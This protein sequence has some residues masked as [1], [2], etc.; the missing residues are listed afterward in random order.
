MD[1][2]GLPI[3]TTVSG[4]ASLPLAVGT[5][6]VQAGSSG[7][8]INPGGPELPLGFDQRLALLQELYQRKHAELLAQTQQAIVSSPNISVASGLT[9][10]LINSD[11]IQSLIQL[12]L[13]QQAQQYANLQ[14]TTPIQGSNQEDVEMQASS[15][16]NP[17]SVVNG[18][19]TAPSTPAAVRSR[20][21]L[22][23]SGQTI[24]QHT[25]DRLKNMIATKKQKQQRLGSSGSSS[26][27]ATNLAVGPQ[28]TNGTGSLT[29]VPPN[30]AA[31]S[32]TNLMQ[33]LAAAAQQ[34]NSRIPAH[35]VASSS[36]FEPYPLPSSANANAAGQMSD[37]QLRKVNSEPNLKMK[38]RARL[39]NKGSSPVAH[40]PPQVPSGLQFLA[41]QSGH[42]QLQRCD[43]DSVQM[44]TLMRS[45]IETPLT[46]TNSTSTLPFPANLMIP[47]PSLPN[48]C[49]GLD[50]LR[51]DYTNLMIQSAFTSF[52]SMPS[53]LK[54]QLNPNSI[55]DPLSADS[56]SSAGEGPSTRPTVK[57]DTRTLS[58]PLPIGGY[59][60]LL[61]QQLRDLVL[62]RKSLVRE[63]PEDEQLMENISQR[64]Q[65][66]SE[67][68]HL[69]QLKTGLAYDAAMSKHQCLCADNSNHV[70]HGGR[71]HS[72]WAR[73][74]E[75]GL[76]DMCERVQMRKATLD[77][78]KL[79]H[80]STYVTFF[81][82]SP[83]ACLKLDPSE[84]PLKSFVPLPCGGIGV[85]SDTYFN[86]ANTQLASRVAVGTLVELSTQ[87]VEGKLKNGFA[88]I[89]PPGHHAEKEQ[90]MGF[91]YF[92][93]VSIATKNLQQKYSEKCKKIA[94]VDWDVHHG[95]GTQLCFDS[96]PNVL[97]ISLHRHDN[98][99][100]FPG[101]GAV[102]DTG[103]EEG[104]GFSVNIPF[105]GDIMGDTEYLAAWRIVVLPLLDAFKPEFIFV[106]AGFDAAK[107]HS[108]AL[109]GYELSPQIF[110][111]FTKTLLNFAN[112]RI[113]LALEGGY[114]L[115][116]ICD[117]AEECVK[118]LCAEGG[119]L[120]RLSPEVLEGIPNQAAQDT[121]Q[122]VI[123][124]HK[125][126]WPCLTGL[127]GLNT[128]ELHWQTIS[129]RFSSL[130][131]HS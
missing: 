113:V 67:T 114:D 96:D 6:D 69:N 85:D 75:R 90:A 71:L 1:A 76:V 126:S 88:C 51:L 14:Q 46:Q 89:R 74:Q 117:S 129:Q 128:S 23:G 44:E 29:W 78:L 130:T 122:K 60:S 53:L 2:N 58:S 103:K 91:C 123:A 30:M 39:L 49:N 82:V 125:K 26:G 97:Y 48:L 127:Q 124:I 40:P 22:S 31:V 119:E 57:F 52:L 106:S 4:T 70:E 112:G 95:N 109:G 5:E 18:E 104:K 66:L 101:T 77:L 102:T 110:G 100:F 80:S 87:V 116:S 11:Y 13:S 65:A 33:Q 8:G 16:S 120:T 19:K 115:P 35:S 43:S 99:N 21:T 63:E 9:P 28:S 45:P 55:L 108:P 73:L 3:H 17:N 27:S 20:R 37:F 86:D 83:T 105:S 68:N 111:Y 24:S 32:E 84:F 79:V 131:V 50:Q 64:I 34:S 54:A 56:N 94:I 92:N 42:R 107:G 15:S 62:R 38:L 81:G 59:P 98:G 41:N 7:V 25:R 93:N 72:I 10:N 36:H 121:I 12:T 47:S 61:K 118:A